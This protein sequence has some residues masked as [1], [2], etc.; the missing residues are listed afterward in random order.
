MIILNNHFIREQTHFHWEW[1]QN[2]NR[3]EKTFVVGI[4]V[5]SS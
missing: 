5:L 4:L 1:V 2:E 3:K